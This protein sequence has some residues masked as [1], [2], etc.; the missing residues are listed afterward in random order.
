MKKYRLTEDHP[1]H[2]KFMKLWDQASDLGLSIHFG[3][4]KC[5][6]E[7]KD[8]P[9]TLFEVEDIESN[10]IV[11]SFPHETEFKITFKKARVE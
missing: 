7:D 4:G 8:N 10:Q 5:W 6:F 9:G 1:T 2:Q 3:S 11:T